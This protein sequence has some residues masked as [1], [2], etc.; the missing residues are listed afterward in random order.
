MIAVLGVIICAWLRTLIN[1]WV[2]YINIASF[3]AAM[4][5]PLQG[6]VISKLVVN[7]FPTNQHSA[8]TIL[9]TLA[10]LLGASIGPFFA[11]AFI[12]THEKN[13]DKA[14]SQV[15]KGLFYL[16]I[17]YTS[18]LIICLLFYKEKPAHPPWYFKKFP[19][20]N[21]QEALES[22]NSEKTSILMQLKK[23]FTNGN[24][25]VYLIIFNFVQYVMACLGGNIAPLMAA[26]GV[27]DTVFF[28]SAL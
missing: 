28:E 18:V 2:Y 12:N 6:N 21:S 8:A 14:K 24:F 22:E 11:L 9:C 23:L 4:V 15:F 10:G 19:I 25:I 26:F 17:I 16:A 13:A 3:P 5:N 7:W 1:Q 27:Y 20:K